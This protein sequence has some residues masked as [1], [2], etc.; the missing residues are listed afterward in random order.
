MD[1]FELIT[2]YS[3]TLITAAGYVTTFFMLWNKIK[4]FSFKKDTEGLES[5]LDKMIKENE[6]LRQDNSALKKKMDILI[7]KTT[8]VKNY[9][10]NIG[11]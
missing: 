6:K 11:G 9:E 7:D 2:L 1:I 8:G 5:K 3:P 4:S 10:Q